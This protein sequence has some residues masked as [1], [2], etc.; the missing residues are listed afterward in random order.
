MR[1]WWAA[2]AVLVVV[3]AGLPGS[4][5]AQDTWISGWG[6]L[7][8]NPGTVQDHESGTR[9]E[10]GTSFMFGGGI[11]RALGQGL[12]AGIDVGYSPVRHEVRDINTRALLDEG[13]AHILTA[14]L[15]GRLGAGRAAGFG[16]YLA[17]GLGA[18]VYGI[19]HLDR[20]DPDFALRGGGGVEYA[21]SRELALFLEWSQWWVFHQS[22]GVQDNTIRHGTLEIGARFRR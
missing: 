7:F 5:A 14:M 22:Q 18:M 13:R 21:P 2:L 20:W 6:G 11:Q 4:G 3:G 16:T 8:L 15:T 1:R 9:W 10:F 19:P 12:V 17:G